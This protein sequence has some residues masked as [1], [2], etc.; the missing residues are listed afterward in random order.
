[1]KIEK[2]KFQGIVSNGTSELKDN[3]GVGQDQYRLKR[4]KRKKR[5]KIKYWA[6]AF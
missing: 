1:M 4:E 2:S 6:F 5:K 3:G